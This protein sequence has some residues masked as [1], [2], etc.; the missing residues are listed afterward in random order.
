[1]RVIG[2]SAKRLQL[3]TLD[4]L[5]TRPTTD[6]IKET[7]FNMISPYLCDCMFLDLFSGSGGIGIEALSRGAKEA[8]FVENNPK[9]MQYI[10]ENLR[11]TKLDKNAVTMQTDVLTALKKLEGK[12]QFDYIFMDPP[13]AKGLEKQV[14]EYLAESDLVNEDTVIIVEAAKETEFTYLEQFGFYVTKTKEYKTNKHL[15]IERERG[16]EVC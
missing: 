1:M 4:G 3:K 11:F 8:V 10:K 16:E 13:Y 15:F 6:R 9:A 7:L 12:T 5:E 2:G 14:L